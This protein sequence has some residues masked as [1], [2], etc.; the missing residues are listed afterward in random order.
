MN[1]KS[2]QPSFKNMKKI[3]LFT[4]DDGL[5]SMAENLVNKPDSPWN[6]AGW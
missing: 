1:T 6:Q 4:A 2:K 5:A 3:V